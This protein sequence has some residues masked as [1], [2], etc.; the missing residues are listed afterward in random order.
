MP[1]QE[2]FPI[3]I[4]GAGFAG[5]GAAIRLKQE[6]IE[7]FTM[8]ERASEVGGTWR[9]NTYPGCACDV[10]SHVY[11]LSFEQNPNWSR[12]YSTWQEIQEYLIGLVDKWGLEKH[13]RRNTEIVS[14][15]F[16][17]EKGTW[18][19]KTNEGD[20]FTARVV[21]SGV[22]GLVDP[23]Y[24]TIDGIDEFSG[25]MFHTARWNHEVDLTDKRV[26]V[27]GTGASAV[28][29][30]PSIASAVAK[31]SVF[32]RTAAWVVPKFDL[33]YSPRVKR[34]AARFPFLLRIARFFKYWLSELLGPIVF[35]DSKLLS[36]IGRSISMWNLRRQVQ[37]PELQKRLTPDFQFGC[38]R[39]LVSDD[40][41]AAFERAN[42]ELITEPIEAIRREGIE[43]TDGKLHVFDVIVLATG[44]LLGLAA[45]PF[46]IRGRGGRTLDEAWRDGAM[47]YKGMTVSGFPNW[48][49]MMGPNTGPGHT[50]VLVY[51]EA[52]IAHALQA[53]KK[54]MAEDIKYCDVRQDVQDRYNEGI[55]RRM[56]HM[57]WGSGCH[58]WYLSSDGR[59]RSLY[60]GFA[61]E[62]ILR[63]RRLNS[64]DYEVAF[65][66]S[67]RQLEES[68]EVEQGLAA[69][70]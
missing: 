6:G 48:F 69:A 62:Y 51:T 37:D 35:L 28:Q 44:F 26:A 4:I 13:L 3:A 45:A 29:V 54:M 55:Q 30:V 38:K 46:Q 68:D 42:V 15:E 47:A 66:E 58:S 17:E 24:P 60:P 64:A 43:T 41:W 1:D 57:V 31:L 7:S 21:L 23:S 19:L 67:E 50:S 16:D 59:N 12:R 34:L 65:F 27:I 39:V 25:D 20:T 18:A 40:Y 9:D 5:I 11:S 63:T 8:F 56:K 61:W 33:E 10:Q 49:T 52:Q 53:I 22:G 36:R 32:Q 2:D 14:A 70:R